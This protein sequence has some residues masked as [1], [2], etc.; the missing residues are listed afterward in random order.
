MN[1]LFVVSNKN[2]KD[3]FKCHSSSIERKFCNRFMFN[4]FVITAQPKSLHSECNSPLNLLV[5]VVIV[6]KISSLHCSYDSNISHYH[7]SFSPLPY[8]I[9]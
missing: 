8:E 7:V 2:C 9:A 4:E 5:V 6:T 1:I 3:F